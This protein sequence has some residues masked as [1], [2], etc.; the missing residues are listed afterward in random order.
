MKGN[1]RIDEVMDFLSCSR[2]TIYR[3]IAAGEIVAF[4]NRGCLLVTVE[5]LD[6]Y[7]DRQVL[8]FQEGEQ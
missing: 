1:L 5:S 8:Q 7:R 3:L 4:K 6:A 2:S